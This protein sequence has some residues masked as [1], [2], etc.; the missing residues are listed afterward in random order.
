MTDRYYTVVGDVVLEKVF[1]PQPKLLIGFH[2]SHIIP[3]QEEMTVLTPEQARMLSEYL[4][5][6][7]EQIG[8]AQKASE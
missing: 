8:V 7:A 2:V 3:R 5:D 1:A 6:N 4:L